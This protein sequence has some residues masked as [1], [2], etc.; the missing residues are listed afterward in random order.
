MKARGEETT[1]I[2]WNA[3]G[4]EIENALNALAHMGPGAATVTKEQHAFDTHLTNYWV[5]T[6]NADST[7]VTQREVFGDGHWIE[8]VTTGLSG[9]GLFGQPYN[10]ITFPQKG[11][12]PF[13]TTIVPTDPSGSHFTAFDV[14]VR[15]NQGLST[16][17]FETDS[18]F[19]IQLQDEFSNVITK[20]PIR[21]VQ[22]ITI[23]ANSGEF[24][25]SLSGDTTEF[26]QVGVSENDMENA[27]E[28][29]G[30]IENITVSKSVARN[31]NIPLRLN[32]VMVIYFLCKSIPL[33][34]QKTQV[35]QVRLLIIVTGT[36]YKA[37]QQV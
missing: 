2:S 7:H 27:L 5:V 19:K 14:P 31:H 25:V 9:T 18:F 35:R 34:Y 29:L 10:H 16:G 33:E 26:L 30:S 24:T 12:S 32:L 15:H 6:F 17:I 8:M 37:L 28:K 36:K 1:A 3:T 11:I 21:E 20:G 22:I 23:D 4:L 13:T